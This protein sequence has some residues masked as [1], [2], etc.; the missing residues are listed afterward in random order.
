MNA[1]GAF[2]GITKDGNVVTIND[3][4][5]LVF[6]KQGGKWKRVLQDLFEERTTVRVTRK[7]SK[8]RVQRLTPAGKLLEMIAMRHVPQAL[9]VVAVLGIA[10]L[11]AGGPKSADELAQ[12]TGSHG[13]TL[14]RVLR[15]LVAAGVLAEDRPGH[16]RLT[17]LGQP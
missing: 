10:D 16:F 1:Y 13:P 14:Y 17:A 12:T 5:T 3:R 6:I 9:H 8:T 7:R 4:S 11:L 15:A 2:K